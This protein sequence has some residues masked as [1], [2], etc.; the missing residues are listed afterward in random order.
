MRVCLGIAIDQVDEDVR[1]MR[2]ISTTP[3]G[4]ELG[5]LATIADVACGDTP[6]GPAALPFLG[7]RL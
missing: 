2:T 1:S 3:A 5:S 4:P 7:D 6:A